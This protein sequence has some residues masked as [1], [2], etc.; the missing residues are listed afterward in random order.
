MPKGAA[1]TEPAAGF[2]LIELLVVVAII[3]II[4]AIATAAFHSQ[5]DKA[6]VAAVAADLKTFHTGFLSYATDND[7]F[8]PD[9]HLNPPYHL[10]PGAGMEDYLPVHRW[11]D[12]TPL[13]GN[14]NWEGPNNYPYAGISLYE[15]TAPA[16]V[17]AMLDDKIDDGDLSQGLFRLTPNSRY[18][19]ILHE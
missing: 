1:R 17:M 3:G 6:R 7:Q 8:P 19:Y 9:S 11:A 14:Y 2:T 13:G 10:P 4:A 12:E 15:A 5:I 18:T 16:S